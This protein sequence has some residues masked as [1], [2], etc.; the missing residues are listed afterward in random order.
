MRTPNLRQ[1]AEQLGKI[2]L[3]QEKTLATAESLT[4][5]GIAAE[6]TA[7]PG[8]SAW[9]CGA[10]VTYVN[11]WKHRFLGVPMDT[12]ERFDAV[13]GQTVHAMLQGLREKTGVDCAIAVSGFAGPSGGLPDRPVGTV[14]VGIAGPGWEAVQECHFKGSRA[15][16]RRQTV[17]TAI[18]LMLDRLKSLQ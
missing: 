14:F 17:R 3:A 18:G 15:Q 11:G 7:I 2:L 6:L 8:S 5:G 9:F 4:G 1:Q 16:I 13:S 10:F 12:L